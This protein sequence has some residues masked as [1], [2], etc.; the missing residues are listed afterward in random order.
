MAKAPKP[1]LLLQTREDDRTQSDEYRSTL[2]ISGLPANQLISYRLEQQ[3][4]GKVDLR[5]YSGIILCGSPFTSTDP[6]EEKTDVQKRVEEDLHKLLDVLVAEDYPFLGACY[7]VGSLAIH[8][9][10]VVDRTYA[11]AVHAIDIT[12]TEDGLKDPLAAGLP[13]VFKGFV[14]HKEAVNQLPDH[15]T[16]L[17]TGQDCPVQMFRI[18]QNLYATQFHPEMDFDGLAHRVR[19]YKA[20][21]Y[22]EPH[23]VET[24]I[25][26]VANE[27]VSGSHQVL[28]NFVQHY[29]AGD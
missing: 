15:A 9:G 29:S 13:E 18:Q 19:V 24:I 22:F 17:A 8:Q 21:G 28:R 14:G 2:Q 12:F 6:D 3:R 5:Q 10:A 27:D 26:N 20:N 25:A 4:L 11:E 23:E 1:F 7:G 16:L